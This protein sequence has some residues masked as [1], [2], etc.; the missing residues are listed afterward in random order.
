MAG[1]KAAL[2]EM[3]AY[4]ENDSH[5]YILGSHSSAA[6]KDG[7]DCS[8]AA[9]KFAALVEGVPLDSYPDFSTATQ[10]FVLVERGWEC[11]RFEKASLMP[12]DIL[13]TAGKGHTVIWYGGDLIIGAEGDWDRRPGDSSGAEICLKQYYDFGYAYIL[14]WPEGREDEL[15]DEQAAQLRFVFDHMHWDETCFS[16]VGNLIAR[17]PITYGEGEDQTTAALGDRLAYIDAHTHAV[18]AKLDKILALLQS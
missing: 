2:A 8:G 15:T 13:L 4:A 9:R 5:G 18:D 10:R 7:T 17:M 14:R 12:G 6:M 1:I 16:G 11:Y 3:L